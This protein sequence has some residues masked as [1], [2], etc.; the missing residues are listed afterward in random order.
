MFPIK[1]YNGVS[2]RDAP[3]LAALYHAKPLHLERTTES[4]ASLAKIPDCAIRV[5]REDG[6]VVAYASLGRG[7]DLCG[8]WR[9][10]L[11][12]P[13]FGQAL[14]LD[15]NFLETI[16]CRRSVIGHC[17]PLGCDKD[18]ITRTSTSEHE[19]PG[20]GIEKQVDR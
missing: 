16:F 12:P 13:K 3:Q 4:F 2:E 19:R 18:H 7:D 6:E 11:L 1:E 17:N 5:A 9:N 15:C 8:G 14:L 10:D 20:F